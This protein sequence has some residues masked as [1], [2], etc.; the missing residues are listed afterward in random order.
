MKYAYTAPDTTDARKLFESLDQLHLVA[1][2]PDR[3]DIFGSN[4]GTDADA[5]L[6]FCHDYNANGFGIYWS[7]NNVIDTFAGKK[8]TKSEITNCRFLHCDIDAPKD[9][10]AFDKQAVTE[11]LQDAECPPS[12]VIDSGNGLGAFW[13]LDG[14]HQNLE[15]I[16]Y[17]NRQIAAAYG[18]DNC[19]NCDR[20]MRVPSFINYPNKTKRDRGCTAVTAGMMVTDSGEVLEAYDVSAS[21]P[22]VSVEAAADGHRRPAIDVN[23]LDE[24]I[25]P[26]TLDEIGVNGSDRAFA[27]VTHPEGNDR[28]AA[29]LGAVRL[30]ALDGKSDQ[31]IAGILCN[32]QY[33]ISQHFLDQKHVNRAIKRAISFV[34]LDTPYIAPN[35]ID[36]EGLMSNMSKT[37]GNSAAIAAKKAVL[38]SKAANFN[39]KDEN[40]PPLPLQRLLSPPEPYPVEALGPFI[41]AAVDAVAKS[42]QLPAAIAAGSA[43]ANVSLAVQ[44]HVDVDMPFVG[45]RP[46]SLFMYSMA[47]SGDRKSKSDKVLGRAIEDHEK[48]LTAQYD[49]IC[50]EQNAKV[51]AHKHK[52]AAILRKAGSKSID[53]MEADIKALGPEPKL[54]KTPMFISTDPTLES[55]QINLQTGQSSQAVFSDEGAQFTTGYGM[56]SERALKT[57]A[58]FSG[59]W[60]GSPIRRARV[61]DGNRQIYGRRMSFHL[62]IQVDTGLTWLGD[63]AIRD[64]GLFGRLL[65][66][67]PETLK[68]TRLAKSRK[69]WE[70]TEIDNAIDV[71]N[72]KIAE[73]LNLPFKFVDDDEDRGELETRALGFSDDAKKLW[74][75]F[76]DEVEIAQCPS[77]PLNPIFSLS[78]KAPEHMSRIAAAMTFFNDPNANE[79]GTEMTRNAIDLMWWYLREALRLNEAATSSPDLALAEKLLDWIDE[80]HGPD[81][82]S[83]ADV[84][85]NGPNALRTKAKAEAIIDILVEH[86]WLRLVEGTQEIAGQ[87][88]RKAYEIRREWI[89]ERRETSGSK[90]AA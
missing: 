49:R 73:C 57:A 18:G 60:D 23:L 51:Q 10:S 53:E 27:A 8:P 31:Q 34:R 74:V 36:I 9:G 89:A 11:K 52:L 17:V 61:L 35:Q 76:H 2:H 59:L 39:K 72:N 33:P 4:F 20:I 21:L 30:L 41:G 46:T 80:K 48:R 15:A 29:G 40:T 84:Y 7:V 63:P 65:I 32:P 5:A 50:F 75:Q 24:D 3:G 47:S 28:S 69:P 55:A 38:E 37:T 85:Q 56:S 54:P 67:C 79:I 82:I 77:C 22:N 12:F 25:R 19:H 26:L 71:Y 66:A 14:P 45:R 13:R 83:A 42:V 86:D 58:G 70:Q 1:I 88:R 44:G 6:K 78:S 90:K 64:Q 16:E 81:F 68:G 87:K 43:L 62:M